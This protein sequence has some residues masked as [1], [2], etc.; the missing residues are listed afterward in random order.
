MVT[1]RPPPSCLISKGPMG[2][3]ARTITPTLT[4]SSEGQ[5]GSDPVSR[6]VSG[7]AQHRAVSPRDCPS[8]NPMRSAEWS[9]GRSGE[10][11]PFFSMANCS[12]Q[13]CE[14]TLWNY[15]GAYLLMRCGI[16]TGAVYCQIPAPRLID[17]VI[18]PSSLAKVPD[19]IS[20]MRPSVTSESHRGSVQ[21]SSLR[22]G[23]LLHGANG[24]PGTLSLRWRSLNSKLHS[25]PGSAQPDAC[26]LT[27]SNF[28][29]KP[30]SP[31][32]QPCK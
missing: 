12:P 18:Q 7:R 19:G 8:P 31:R 6:S 32:R 17:S 2:W 4:A 14:V 9:Y 23:A 22:R 24:N 25:L 1:R 20:T 3:R 29:C 28:L 16:H 13:W 15:T 30:Y 21:P 11:P 10:T 5:F 27:T 26:D